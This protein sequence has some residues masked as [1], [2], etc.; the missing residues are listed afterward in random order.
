VDYRGGRHRCLLKLL[1]WQS[2][3]AT[4]LSDANLC[5]DY[6]MLFNLR[7]CVCLTLYVAHIPLNFFFEGSLGENSL[8]TTRVF[9]SG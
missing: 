8:D 2:L 7:A 4:V 9:D 1:A 3:G 6:F 5:E